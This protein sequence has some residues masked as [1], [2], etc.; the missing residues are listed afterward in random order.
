VSRDEEAELSIIDA[1][2]HERVRQE[3]EL[4]RTL[5]NM[6]QHGEFLIKDHIGSNLISPIQNGGEFYITRNGVDMVVRV[7]L[8]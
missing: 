7:E 1:L 5:E 6:H 4:S 2:R 3:R 8:L